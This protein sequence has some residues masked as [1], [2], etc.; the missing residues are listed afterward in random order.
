MAGLICVD[1]GL[2]GRLWFSLY[3]SDSTIFIPSVNSAMPEW[4]H[5]PVES[6]TQRRARGWPPK[7]APCTHQLHIHC[8]CWLSLA[9]IWNQT[10][11]IGKERGKNEYL[12]TF[13]H[14][15]NKNL[16]LPHKSVLQL[17]HTVRN[18]CSPSPREPVLKLPPGMIYMLK[19]EHFTSHC[20]LAGKTA[21]NTVCI[22]TNEILKALLTFVYVTSLQA[23]LNK[24]G[25]YDCAI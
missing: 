12:V 3:H 5:F 10:F 1:K 9:Q 20:S 23:I 18:I 13:F 19:A 6:F 14:W 21:L 11:C 24:Y 15:D 16:Y 2:D 17:D 22:N 7:S 8:S 25:S 4:H